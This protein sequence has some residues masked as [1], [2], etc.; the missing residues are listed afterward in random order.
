MTLQH[1]HSQWSSKAAVMRVSPSKFITFDTR[2]ELQHMHALFSFAESSPLV[3]QHTIPAGWRPTPTM[4]DLR[5]GQDITLQW[6]EKLG[7]VPEDFYWYGDDLYRSRP[8]SVTNEVNFSHAVSTVQKYAMQWPE[9]ELAQ[10]ALPES[11]VPYRTISMT[12]SG[13]CDKQ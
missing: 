12:I 13:P 8:D 10:Q 11:F 4:V 9:H 5:P 3:T 7:Q 1:E 6:A 2:W